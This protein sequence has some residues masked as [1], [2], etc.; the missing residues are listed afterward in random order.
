M[1]HMNRKTRVATRLGKA[2]L[3]AMIEQATV[4]AYNEAEQTTGWFTMLEEH[5]ALPFEAKMLG[6]AVTVTSI[7]LRGATRIVAICTRGGERQAVD[8]V[9]LPLPPP[10]PDGAEWVDAYRYWLPEG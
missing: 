4:D 7:D 6:V 8:L 5:L 3:R 9:D 10:K 1:T 2:K